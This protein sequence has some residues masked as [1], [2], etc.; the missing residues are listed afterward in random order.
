MPKLKKR[1]VKKKYWALVYGGLTFPKGE[2]EVSLSRNPKNR[3][4]FCVSLKGR[5][6]MT[7][8]KSLAVYSFLRSPAN[9]PTS[10]VKEAVF[11]GG[12]SE[13][14]TLLEVRP[15][16]GRTHQIRVHLSYIGHPV[17]GDPLYSGRKKFRRDRVWCP[18]LFLHA[19]YLGFFHP[20]SGEWA[21]FKIKL[22]EK[23]GGV[24]EKL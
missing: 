8:Y 10:E 16:T 13:K 22:P 23:L 7:Q 20:E 14:F 6:A 5:E 19:F 11:L 24:L 18:R 17:V 12:A 21:E 9:S 3:R 2:I 1:K 4:K 15:I